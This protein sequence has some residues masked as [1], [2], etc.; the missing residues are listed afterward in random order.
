[1][2]SSNEKLREYR[3]LIDDTSTSLLVGA[4]VPILFVGLLYL[5]PSDNINLTSY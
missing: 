1:M 5:S 2:F 3:G 4:H